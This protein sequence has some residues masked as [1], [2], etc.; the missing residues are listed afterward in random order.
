M[1]VEDVAVKIKEV[2]EKHPQA[3]LRLGRPI[4]P[5]TARV[6]LQKNT[7]HDYKCIGTHAARVH[8]VELAL[9]QEYFNDHEQRPELGEFLEHVLDECDGL[10]AVGDVERDVKIELG[11]HLHE[12]NNG[13]LGFRKRK[14]VPSEALPRYGALEI[15][16][17]PRNVARARIQNHHVHIACGKVESRSEGAE[18]LSAGLRPDP[19]DHAPHAIDG[20]L[21]NAL[22][23]GRR[24]DEIREA[25]DLLVKPE[26]RR[27][28]PTACSLPRQRYAVRHRL[29]AAAAR[30][31]AAVVVIVVVRYHHVLLPRRRHRRLRSGRGRAA[32]IR[33]LRQGNK[34]LIGPLACTL[35]GLGPDLCPI[36][37]VTSDTR[38]VARCTHV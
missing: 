10:D 4:P 2:D 35:C 29:V 21:P 26:K 38:I 20:G 13:H 3:L 17:S 36:F 25:Y 15:V 6:R 18:D 9:L 8:L 31:R 11:L 19:E 14:Q 5:V 23:L 32:S 34:G 12:L 7:H 28:N 33:R 16:Q 24:L 37:L 30:A 22:L 27:V 1:V